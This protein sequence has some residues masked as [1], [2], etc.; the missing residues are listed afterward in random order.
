MREGERVKERERE[1]ERERNRQTETKRGALRNCYV[2]F[3]ITS[4]L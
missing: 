4:Y 1:R 2:D 3:V